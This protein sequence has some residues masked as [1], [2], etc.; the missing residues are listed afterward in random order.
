MFLI[1]ETKPDIMFATSIVS[2]FAK[3]LLYQHTENNPA[4][5]EDDEG[6]KNHLRKKI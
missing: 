5:F 6:Y 1:I 3:N 4:I 2:Q